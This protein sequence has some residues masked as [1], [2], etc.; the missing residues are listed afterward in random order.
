MNH[1]YGPLNFQWARFSVGDCKLL[2]GEQLK[3]F[4]F[5]LHLEYV[6]QAEKRLEKSFQRAPFYLYVGINSQRVCEIRRLIWFGRDFW[7]PS[8]RSKRNAY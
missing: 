7:R 8:P 4:A 1:Y 2:C 6:T 5:N 3:V